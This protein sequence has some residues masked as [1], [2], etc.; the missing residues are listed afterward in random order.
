VRFW[1]RKRQKKI[2]EI[3]LSSKQERE[4]CLNS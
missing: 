1:M 3:A 2:K 4:R